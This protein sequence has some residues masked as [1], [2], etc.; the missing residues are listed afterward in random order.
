MIREA[1]VITIVAF[2]TSGNTYR[3]GDEES[4]EVL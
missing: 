3:M 1:A 2:A 4:T